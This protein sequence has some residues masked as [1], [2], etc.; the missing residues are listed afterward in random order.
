MLKVPVFE[1]NISVEIKG[2]AGPVPQDMAVR[3]QW[4]QEALQA[5]QDPESFYYE[6]QEDM[7]ADWAAQH[8]IDIARGK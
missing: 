8:A 3:T 5:Y 7:A 1:S 2:K 4:V 6:M